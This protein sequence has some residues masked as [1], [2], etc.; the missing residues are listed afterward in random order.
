MLSRNE[1]EPVSATETQHAA[2]STT[3]GCLRPAA[4]GLAP[5]RVDAAG[6]PPNHNAGLSPC[7]SVSRARRKLLTQTQQQTQIASLRSSASARVRIRSLCAGTR[8]S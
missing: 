5:S 2:R 1:K 7:L 3:T 4:G 8:K 6:L